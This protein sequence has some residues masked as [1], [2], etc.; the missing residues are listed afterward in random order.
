MPW[1]GP[2]PLPVAAPLLPVCEECVVAVGPVPPDV[3]V[4]VSDE[5]VGPGVG[6]A[7]LSRLFDE[8]PHADKT[9]MVARG[10]IDTSRGKYMV[11]T[12]CLRVELRKQHK[13]TLV[14][15]HVKT[16]LTQANGPKAT[17]LC[18]QGLRRDRVTLTKGTETCYR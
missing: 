8:P 2:L 1:L 6:L 12:A 15:K 10:K 17:L 7:P 11:L 4:G 13:L 9:V 18:W 5:L 14:Y 3:S 16:N